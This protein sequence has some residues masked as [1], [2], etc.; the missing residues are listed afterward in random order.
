MDLALSSWKPAVA[1]AV[2]LVSAT[3]VDAPATAADSTSVTIGTGGVTGVYYPTGGAVCRLVNKG[4]RSHGVRCSAESTG[5]SIYNI[6]TIRAGELDFGLAQSDWQY[7]AYNGTS[8]FRNSGAFRELRSVF[9][10]YA[11]PLTIV[12]RRDSGIRRLRDLRGKRV[13]IG[14]PGSGQRG[15]ME[16]VMRA[17]GW[18]SGSFKLASELRFSKQGKALCDNKIDAAVFVGGH[19]SGSVK[20][21]TGSCDTVLVDVSGP[22]I[23]RLVAANPYYRHSVIPGGMYRGSRSDVPTFGVGATIVT[24]AR[25]PERVVYEVVK[26][27]FRNLDS[28]RKLHPAFKHLNPREMVRDSLSAPLH[29]GAEKYYREA[30]LYDGAIA[31]VSPPPPTPAPPPAVVPPPAPP[32]PAPEPELEPVDAPFVVLKNA[33]IRKNP[34]VRA[35]RVTMLRANRRITAL[36][37]VAGKNW[38]LVAVDGKEIGYVFGNLIKPA[39]TVAAAPAPSTPPPAPASTV[40]QVAGLDLGRFHAIVIGNDRYA[41]FPPLRNAVRD[42]EAVARVLKRDYIFDDV[43][44]MRNATRADI[45]RALSRMRKRLTDRDNLLIYYAGHGWR[46]E[47]AAQGFWLPVDA[48]RDD[49]I[50]WVANESITGL[51]RA[52]RAKHVMVIADSCFSGT[53]TRGVKVEM[54]QPDHLQRMAS[55][56]A[57]TALTSG[58]LEPVEDGGGGG[59]SVFAKALLDALAANQGVMDASELFTRLRRPV[60]VNSEQTPEYG[61]IRKAGHDGGDFL[62][63]RR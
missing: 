54:R 10:V 33:N 7:H 51:V 45:L 30:G 39:P 16:T 49:P 56:R 11:E 58:G 36:G 5:G 29:R 48:A 47:A 53:L 17:L 35:E 12:A 15:T 19:P 2:L 6:N 50:N 61:D 38:Y 9:S 41:E 24:S 14:N 37:K 22:E 27:V 28:F 52:M 25:V 57:R 62:F 8:K 44:V 43:A 55:K 21:A 46:D 4:R 3:S 34:N 42:A 31:A 40:M 1:F 59:H 23:D 32:R 20:V 13:N 26:S 63:A 18:T 60:M